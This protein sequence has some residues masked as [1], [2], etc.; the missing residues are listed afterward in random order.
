M[1]E[2]TPRCW[3]KFAFGSSHQRPMPTSQVRTNPITRWRRFNARSSSRSGR[4]RS[5]RNAVLSS[6]RISGGQQ[7]GAWIARSEVWRCFQYSFEPGTALARLFNRIQLLHQ[8]QEPALQ[9]GDAHVFWPEIDVEQGTQ[10]PCPVAK[11]ATFLFQAG[12]QRRAGKGGHDRDLDL[13]QGGVP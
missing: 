6:E 4:K 12:I 2:P 9:F 8:S 13:I 11:D 7:S 3:S 1:T 10:I 5:R